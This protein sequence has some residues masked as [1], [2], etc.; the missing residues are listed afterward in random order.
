MKIQK[1][2]K[3]FDVAEKF[4]NELGLEY[5]GLQRQFVA[6]IR[7][8]LLQQ[9]AQVRSMTDNKTWVDAMNTMSQRID[10]LY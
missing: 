3:R 10:L 7:E 4:A 2:E 1:I 5:T 6:K 8:H 9:A